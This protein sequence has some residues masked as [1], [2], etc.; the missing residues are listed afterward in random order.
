[1]NVTVP[2]R[3]VIPRGNRIERVTTAKVLVYFFVGF[4]A[5]IGLMPMILVTMISITSD[6]SIKLNGYQLFPKEFSLSAYR[7]IF[8]PTSSVMPAYGVSI[9]VTLLGTLA[10]VLI[11]GMAAFT[12][13]NKSVHY[14]NSL[15]LFFFVPMVF[16]A[17]LVPWYMMCRALGLKDNLLSLIIPSLM[18]SAYN[19]FLC[20]NFM[21]SLPDSFMESAKLDGATDSQIAFRIYFPLSTPVL[22]AIAL[23]YGVAY[24]NDWFNA[25]MLVDNDKLFPLQYMLYKIKSEIAAL[26]R[27]QPDVPVRNL[28]GESLKMATALVTIGPIIFLYPFLQKYFIKGLIIGGVKG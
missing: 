2:N 28:P 5:L 20:R 1:M 19:M 13:C 11:T 15:A 7:L 3:H 14:R 26:Q 21:N 10:A 17:G 6:A 18:F 23:F 4:F 27:L 25:I 24:W 16:N 8:T 12:L 9:T 22:A